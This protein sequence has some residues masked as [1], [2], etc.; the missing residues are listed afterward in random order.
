MLT[1]TIAGLLDEVEVFNLALSQ[2]EIQSI[3]NAGSSGKCKPLSELETSEFSA[4]VMVNQHAVRATPTPRPR[5]TP[6]ARPT[7]ATSPHTAT[8][9][10]YNYAYRSATTH[11]AFLISHQCRLR[12]PRV[13]L[14]GRGPV[15]NALSWIGVGSTNPIACVPRTISSKSPKRINDAAT[16]GL[17]ELQKLQG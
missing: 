8:P 5:P 15:R 9:T 16:Q 13:L 1:A 12:L 2:S 7:S 11:S 10:S 17:K 6:T 14:P 3:V 4:C